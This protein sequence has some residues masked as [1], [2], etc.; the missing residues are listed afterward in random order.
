MNRIYFT[1]TVMLLLGS[2]LKAQI[3]EVS[4]GA[5]YSNQTFYNLQDGST[6]SIAHT[7]WDIAF[8]IA[9]QSAG[10]FVNEGTASTFGAPAPEVTVY[11]SLD[12]DFETADTTNIIYSI[13][14]DEHNWDVGAFNSFADPD[15]PFDFGWGT[16]NVTNHTV[17]SNYIFFI[18]LRSGQWRKLEI[19]LLANNIYTFRHANLDG[20]DEISVQIDKSNFTDKTLAYYSFTENEVKDLEP[21]NW[22]LLFA[23]YYTPLDDGEGGTIAY[24]VTGV[25]TNQGVEV[26][27]ADGVDPTTVVYQDY[28]ESFQDTLTTIGHEWKFYDFNTGW[29]IQ[30]DQA[31]FVKTETDSI[32]KVQ[33]L[34]FSGATSGITTLSK[35]YEGL[36]VNSEDLITSSTSF[37]LF[38]N[39]SQGLI[40][41]RWESQGAA[42]QDGLLQMINATG[43]IVYQQ[44]ID[45]NTGLN[46]YQFTPA[47]PAGP[48]F[49][50]LQTSQQQIVR[51]VIL[52]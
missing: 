37:Q 45:V 12:E 31:F 26:A 36:L 30:E 47:V 4:I 40:N 46:T 33:F 8:G 32:W 14:N 48:Y 23:R 10:I 18:Q 39:P 3:E 22:D 27:Q 9:P 5:N 25:L 6:T 29:G 50:T 1:L 17:T 28:L 34:D 41:L 44:L 21:V 7:S 20:S 11:L 24:Q 2:N 38:P 49:I 43:Q 52:D 35:S 15:N 16:Y 51:Q 13:L 42:E 19:Q